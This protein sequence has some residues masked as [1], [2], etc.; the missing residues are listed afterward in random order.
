MAL[1][2]PPKSLFM[3]AQYTA[4]AHSSFAYSLIYQSKIAD[5]TYRLGCLSNVASAAAEISQLVH[6]E[7]FNFTQYN[8]QIIML[9]ELTRKTL[10]SAGV[11]PY[12][13]A[14][15]PEHLMAHKSAYI[16]LLRML[17]AN[18]RYVDTKFQK[19]LRVLLM[20][21]TSTFTICPHSQQ[22]V[23]GSTGSPSESRN[24]QGRILSPFS[25]Y[26]DAFDS[27]SPAADLPSSSMLPPDAFPA[28][29]T[30]PPSD[31]SP[32]S[33]PR[34]SGRRIWSVSD[35]PPLAGERRSRTR[36]PPQRRAP[37]EEDDRENVAPESV[38]FHQPVQRLRFG[39]MMTGRSSMLGNHNRDRT[40]RPNH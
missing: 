8:E 23:L 4:S 5:L 9:I 36:D 35:L 21:L 37:S 29:T 22:T 13:W 18:E 10:E 31:P 12:L 39:I 24:L 28:G 2:P 7:H 34:P 17:R 6:S 40:G 32:P 16:D 15:C 26:R 19:R 1:H 38:S 27:A 14:S 30:Q 25:D 11:I 33:E 3:P 20:P